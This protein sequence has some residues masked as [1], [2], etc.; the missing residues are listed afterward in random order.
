M[1]A[2]LFKY[3]RAPLLGAFMTGL[4]ACTT[5]SGPTYTL[6]AVSAPNQQART[7][8]VSCLGLFESSNS[9]VRV[10]EE[11]CKTQPVT[12]LQAIDGVSDGTPKNL[13]RFRSLSRKQFPSRF[14]SRKQNGRRPSVNC[15]CKAT[16]ISQPIVR[17]LARL[18]R[19]TL[20]T[21]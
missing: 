1:K 5:Q 19:A 8:R 15:C 13:R 11:T 16:R 18:Q 20:T 10:A 3:L 14:L 12:W 7:Y 9:G 4:A 2:T 21:L 17:C 6:H